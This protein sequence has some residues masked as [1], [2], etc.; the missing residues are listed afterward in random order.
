MQ[1]YDIE[2][3]VTMKDS[4]PLEGWNVVPIFSNPKE[5]LNIVYQGVLKR[6]GVVWKNSLQYN[7]KNKEERPYNSLDNWRFVLFEGDLVE[8]RGLDVEAGKSSKSWRAGWIVR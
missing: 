1:E 3:F 5:H 2:I 4:Q 8:V 7:E 6:L